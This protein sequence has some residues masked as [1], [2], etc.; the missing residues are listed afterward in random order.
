MTTSIRS[1]FPLLDDVTY[2]NSASVCLMPLVSQEAGRRFNDGVY[3][4]RPDALDTW[5]EQMESARRTVANFIGA[6]PA[7]IAFT[8]NSGDGEA[9]V[10]NGLSFKAGQNIVID[11]LDFPS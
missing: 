7:E 4:G 5:L 6:Q 11:D 3:R 2:L 9:F 1:Q 10:A 8:G